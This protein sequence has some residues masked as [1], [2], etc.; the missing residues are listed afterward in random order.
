MKPDFGAVSNQRITFLQPPLYRHIKT[1]NEA[2]SV[3]ARLEYEMQHGNRG[4]ASALAL[5]AQKLVG[6][7]VQATE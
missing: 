3:I 5:M 1:A 6:E 4:T 7:L 2:R